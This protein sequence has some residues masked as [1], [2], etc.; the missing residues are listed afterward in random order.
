MGYCIGFHEAIVERDG[1]RCAAGRTETT[2][3]G[4]EGVG[5]F[6]KSYTKGLARVPATFFFLLLTASMMHLR[7]AGIS[8]AHPG[9]P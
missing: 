3:Q 9:M 6:W 8:E 4:W 1:R 5:I 7:A 2:R